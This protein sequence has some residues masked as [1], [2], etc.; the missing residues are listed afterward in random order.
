MDGYARLARSGV[1]LAAE[2]R[3]ACRPTARRASRHAEVDR[4]APA[5]APVVASLVSAH[6]W[7]AVS[8]IEM[9]AP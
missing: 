9:P 1:P 3:S 5:N 7:A 8:V 2:S 6:S 4:P